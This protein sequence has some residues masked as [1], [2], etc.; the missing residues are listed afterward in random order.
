VE[1]VADTDPQVPLPF[2]SQ[3]DLASGARKVSLL[4]MPAGI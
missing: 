2:D 3:I 4:E 1:R